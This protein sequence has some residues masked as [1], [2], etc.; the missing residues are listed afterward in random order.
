M[1]ESSTSK[2]APKR[3]WA[4]T[5]FDLEGIV[6][7]LA[8]WLVGILLGWLW[9]PLFWIGA[10]L[11][12]IILLAT[13]RQARVAPEDASLVVAP[14]D[15][16]VHSVETAT[17]PSEL[18]MDGSE[19]VRVRVASSPFST[20]R[21]YASMTG[22]IS[23]IILEEPDSSVVLASQ[24][25]LSGLAVAHV[26]LE[27]LG[28][29]IGYRVATGGFGPRLEMISE[30]GDPVRTGRVIGQRRLGGWCDIYLPA[31][32]DVSVVAGQTLI[33][34]ETVLCHLSS[35][36]AVRAAP[37]ATDE[38]A[39]DDVVFA[40]EAKGADTAITAGA[41]AQ[42][43]VASLEELGDDA[44]DDDDFKDPEDAA[45]ALFKKLKGQSAGED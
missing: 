17:A 27:S 10:G 26:A 13:R 19:F 14:C 37:D 23:S 28:Q 21:V 38:A 22:E 42:E 11:A 39:D 43:A 41:I 33:G 32:T 12:V 35:D 24:P 4:R 30:A 1:S 45:A 6:G 20:N 9:S 7:A 29:K 15:G 5:S 31:G 34:A 8:A 2:K 3:I 44:T 25:D 16:V 36:S 18:R 40:D